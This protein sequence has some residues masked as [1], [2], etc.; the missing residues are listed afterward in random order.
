MT[1]TRDLRR[2]MPYLRLED[3]YCEGTAPVAHNLIKIC[4]FLG[5]NCQKNHFEYRKKR[6]ISVNGG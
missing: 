1:L 2:E 4:R 5:L 6:E 3:F